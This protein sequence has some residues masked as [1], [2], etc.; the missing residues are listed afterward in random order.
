MKQKKKLELIPA[1]MAQNIQMELANQTAL[2]VMEIVSYSF[3]DIKSFSE[4]LFARKIK[5]NSSFIITLDGLAR[6]RALEYLKNIEPDIEKNQ[7]G[8]NR[9]S[10]DWGDER[11]AR[12]LGN[13]VNQ[14][15]NYTPNEDEDTSVN[16]NPIKVILFDDGTIIFLETKDGGHREDAILRVALLVFKLEEAERTGDLDLMEEAK[17]IFKKVPNPYNNE[18]IDYFNDFFVENPQVGRLKKFLNESTIRINVVNSLYSVEEDNV[19]KGYVGNDSLHSNCHNEPFYKLIADKCE[20]SMNTVA[21]HNNNKNPIPSFTA[22]VVAALTVAGG[23]KQDKTKAMAL[24]SYLFKHANKKQLE[25]LEKTVNTMF[26]IESTKGVYDFSKSFK[27]DGTERHNLVLKKK[28]YRTAYVAVVRSNCT[29]I[30]EEFRNVFGKKVVFPANITFEFIDNFL[31]NYI[32][33]GKKYYSEDIAT[34][35][36]RINACLIIM[37]H[38]MKF[39]KSKDFKNACKANTDTLDDIYGGIDTTQQTNSYPQ[40][41]EDVEKMLRVFAYICQDKALVK[42]TGGKKNATSRVGVSGTSRTRNNAGN[43]KTVCC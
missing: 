2:P 37:E 30:Y 17:S 26:K 32:F 27:K 35:A 20:T 7:I 38:S 39:L 40:K 15:E 21:F 18:F 4:Y 6:A 36:Q 19:A 34:V 41:D 3:R 12:F 43:K 13:L 42:K 8:S 28:F 24:F 16:F 11:I 10:D 33:G 9:R 25:R 23:I 14:M 31:T 1:E 22:N 29:G 5:E